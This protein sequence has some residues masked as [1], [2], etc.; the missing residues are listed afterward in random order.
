M[1]AFNEAYIILCNL[2]AKPGHIAVLPVGGLMNQFVYKDRLRDLEQK[3]VHM[4]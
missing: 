1:H 3:V 2:D 4:K